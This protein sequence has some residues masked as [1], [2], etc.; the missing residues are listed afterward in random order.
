[1]CFNYIFKWDY[2]CKWKS[3][4]DMN[5]KQMLW[6]HYEE[7]K[8]C[9]INLLKVRVKKSWVLCNRN[10]WI[11]ESVKTFTNILQHGC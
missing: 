2:S 7:L 5:V 6:R 3:I 11:S 10:H 8:S 1:M 9:M 4:A